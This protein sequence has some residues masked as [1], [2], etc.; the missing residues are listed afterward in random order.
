M[1]VAMPLKTL[2]DLSIALTCCGTSV[3]ICQLIFESAQ[4]SA[5]T[6]IGSRA[7][8]RVKQLKK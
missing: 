3:A 2:F 5:D 7:S 6:C 8:A 4:T 1:M